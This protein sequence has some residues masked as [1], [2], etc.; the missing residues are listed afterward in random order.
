[1]VNQKYSSKNTSI[2][3]NRLPS[4]S[5]KFH[6]EKYRGQK[7]LDIGGGKFN[8]LKD[9]LKLNYNIELYIYDK[10]NRSEEENIKALNIKP[11]LVI[12][13]NVL[14]VIDNDNVIK[15]IV[16]NI[17]KYDRDFV[18]SVYEG[19]RK[20]EGKVSKKDCY[21]RNQ[22]LKDYVKFFDSDVKIVNGMICN[23]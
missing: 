4:T 1:M 23:V 22:K 12:C 2:N 13:N 10:Y 17:E 11:S 15:G 8:N 16:Q 18:I 21:Q 7:V 14:N 6:W 9:W 5:K 3:K 19:D 20:G